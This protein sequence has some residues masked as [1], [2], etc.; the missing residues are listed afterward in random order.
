MITVHDIHNSEHSKNFN[1]LLYIIEIVDLSKGKFLDVCCDTWP[2]SSVKSRAGKRLVAAR[3]RCTRIAV[4]LCR[5]RTKA[6][7]LRII[8]SQVHK[9]KRQE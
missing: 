8:T 4:S 7:S 9:R 2:M 6:R 3:V 5:S 1:Y